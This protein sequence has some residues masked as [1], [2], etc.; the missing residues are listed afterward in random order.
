MGFRNKSEDPKI[1]KNRC[2]LEKLYQHT[3]KYV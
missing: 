1:E 3:F 2:I